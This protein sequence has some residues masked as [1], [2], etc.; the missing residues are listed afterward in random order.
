MILRFSYH[1]A[2]SELAS[3]PWGPV[4]ANGVDLLTEIYAIYME[5]HTSHPASRIPK[6]MSI[7]PSAAA[8]EVATHGRKES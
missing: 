5:A 2:I 1:L 3:C 6:I 8:G 4:T 7:G